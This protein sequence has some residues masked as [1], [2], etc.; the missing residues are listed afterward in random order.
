MGPR[1]RPVRPLRALRTRLNPSQA[2]SIEKKMRGMRRA[3]N[4]E[5][6]RGGGR[7]ERGASLVEFALILPVFMMLLLGMFTGGMAYNRRLTITSAAREG[8]RYA[9]T[10]PT[11]AYGT[12][13]LWLA[14]VAAVVET[15]A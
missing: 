7:D 12:V 10:L 8:G 13:D 9:A 14:D 15:S 3:H 5:R 1:L 4:R 11:A 6:T 2:G